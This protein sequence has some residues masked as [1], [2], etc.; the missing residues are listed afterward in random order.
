MYILSQCVQLGMLEEAWRIF[1]WVKDEAP[2]YFQDAEMLGQFNLLAQALGESGYP[3]D[4]DKIRMEIINQRP[5]LL[6]KA[7]NRTAKQS[8]SRGSR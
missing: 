8:K 3:E 6:A 5:D 7:L 2:Q 1:C 4:Q